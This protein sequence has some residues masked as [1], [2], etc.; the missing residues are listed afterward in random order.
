MCV[1]A[2]WACDATIMQVL[3]H[4][5]HIH[6]RKHTHIYTHAHTHIHTNTHTYTHKHTQVLVVAKQRLETVVDQRFDEAVAQ[7]DAASATRFARL[8]KPL[9]KQVRDLKRQVAFALSKEL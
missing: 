7:R 3:S 9:G 6:T 1:V 5:T 8:Y 4:H 2:L